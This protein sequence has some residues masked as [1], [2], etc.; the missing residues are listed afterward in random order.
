VSIA[1]LGQG[2]FRDVNTAKPNFRH[3]YDSV[4]KSATLGYDYCLFCAQ[5]LRDLWRSLLSC[6]VAV[7]VMIILPVLCPGIEGFVEKLAAGSCHSACLTQEGQVR[8]NILNF[9]C[10]IGIV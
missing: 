4:E 8:K 7:W 3:I 2:V 9:S 1:F 6:T 10:I 5:G